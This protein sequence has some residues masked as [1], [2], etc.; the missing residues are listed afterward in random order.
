MSLERLVPTKL[1]M[2]YRV[3]SASRTSPIA[4]NVSNYNH[5]VVIH[6]LDVSL[7]SMESG[8]ENNLFA[9]AVKRFVLTN[10]SPPPASQRE[11]LSA[12]NKKIT[13]IY[14]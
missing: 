4:A 8:G 5:V 9:P 7:S 11:T 14:D 1:M 13:T 6:V 12:T 3:V 2:V 10:S